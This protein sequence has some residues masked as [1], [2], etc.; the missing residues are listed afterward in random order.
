VDSFQQFE[1]KISRAIEVLKRVQTEKKALEHELD[2]VKSAA[3]ER[4]RESEAQER[5]LVALRREREEVR[6]RVE[7]LLEQ[8]DALTKSDGQQ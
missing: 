1:E 5:E 2:R 6:A 3:K 8:V 7:K 4:S